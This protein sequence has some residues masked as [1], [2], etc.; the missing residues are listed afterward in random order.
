MERITHRAR[1]II[2]ALFL[3]EVAAVAYWGVG[4]FVGFGLGGL[5]CVA[6]VAYDTAVRRDDT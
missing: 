1:L 6:Y 3:A 4:A 2:G 5:V